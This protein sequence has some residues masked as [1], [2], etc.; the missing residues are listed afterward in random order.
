LHTSFFIKSPHILLPPISLS[1]FSFEERKYA[2]YAIYATELCFEPKFEQRVKNEVCKMY[3][4]K[5]A[6]YA[7]KYPPWVRKSGGSGVE[8]VVV[9]MESGGVA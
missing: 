8:M 4:T 2:I 7:S 1:F 9:G 6:I 5:R 3:A